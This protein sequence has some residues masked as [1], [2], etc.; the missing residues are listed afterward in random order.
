M[1]QEAESITCPKTTQDRSERRNAR[2]IVTQVE[3]E[4][5]RVARISL[6]RRECVSHDARLRNT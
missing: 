2:T 5:G 1:N 6:F 3:K 4:S